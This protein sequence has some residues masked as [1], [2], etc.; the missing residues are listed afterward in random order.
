[1]PVEIRIG[2]SG[3]YYAH[4][5]G[6]LYPPELSKRKWLEYYARRFPTVE[7]NSTFYHLP[8]AATVEHWME[9]T[10]EG[11]LF[12]FKAPRAITHYRKLRDAKE[13]LVRFLHLIKPIRSKTAAVLFQLPPSLH[14]DDALLAEFLSTL[15][16]R[17]AW[18]F[19]IEFRHGS[20]YDDAV[21]ELLHRHETALC[22]HD[23]GRGESPR[24]E[25]A[26]FVYLRLHGKNGHYRGSY[27]EETLRGWADSLRKAQ[28]HKR[29]AFV[30][31]NNDFDGDAVIDARR[32]AALLGIV[33][34]ETPESPDAV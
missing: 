12:S 8:K 19:A 30:Y 5:V 2:T 17:S 25:T 24:V 4:W 7:L 23:Y 11:F 20:W 18:R 33:S 32:L 6:I 16:H 1:M 14:R 31:F 26:P 34:E 3:F 21:Y 9:K 28:R 29:E 27:D 10:P 13:D 15:P 22:W